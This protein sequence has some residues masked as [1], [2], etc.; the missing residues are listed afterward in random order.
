M[1]I[2][3]IVVVSSGIGRASR[4][5]QLAA[6]VS[7]ALMVRAAGP[8]QIH[9]L[10]LTQLAPLLLGHLERSRLPLD[11]QLALERVETADILVVATPVYR[12]SYTGLFKHFFDFVDQNALVDVPVVLVATGGSYRHALVVDHSLRPLF[13]FF[14]A[15]AIPT[16]LYATAADFEGDKIVD[17]E[18]R[19]RIEVAALQA[20]RLADTQQRPLVRRDASRAQHTATAGAAIAATITS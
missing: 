12:G 10:E 8:V 6:A 14:R 20:L 19:T 13:C 7:D 16:A 9:T 5:S 1:A 3:Q 17:S 11:A 4:T 15:Q 18:L 2:R